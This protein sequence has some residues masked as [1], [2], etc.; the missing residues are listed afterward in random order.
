MTFSLEYDKTIFYFKW[1]NILI[2]WNALQEYFIFA[3]KKISFEI[4]H[5]N[6]TKTHLGSSVLKSCQNK[7][8][9]SLWPE[10]KEEICI[11]RKRQMS[12]FS[13]LFSIIFIIYAYTTRVLTMTG[14]SICGQILFKNIYQTP[15]IL[16]LRNEID[17]I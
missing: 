7:L 2:L 13:Q 14:A 1:L 12:P 11:K 9:C 6:K 3:S 10:I 16:L 5:D 15:T 8:K 17:I 4:G